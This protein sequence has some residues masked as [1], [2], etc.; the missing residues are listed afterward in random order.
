MKESD[1]FYLQ[2]CHHHSRH[3]RWINL[4]DSRVI[5]GLHDNKDGCQAARNVPR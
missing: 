4:D 1:A 5:Q 2:G 3:T